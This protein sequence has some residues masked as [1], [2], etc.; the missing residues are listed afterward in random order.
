VTAGW[1]THLALDLIVP[2][3]PENRTTSD[4][5][6]HETVLPS[7]KAFAVTE[8]TAAVGADLSPTAE[9]EGQLS[10]AARHDED[11][12]KESFRQVEFNQCQEA[13][14]ILRLSEASEYCSDGR[15]SGRIVTTM[16]DCLTEET[17]G[18]AASCGETMKMMRA[19]LRM[20]PAYE[21][22]ALIGT[23]E[24]PADLFFAGIMPYLDLVD[25]RENARLIESG[26]I[27]LSQL[28]RDKRFEDNLV[29]WA[30]YWN[31]E[32]P[33]AVRMWPLLSSALSK[34]TA[35]AISFN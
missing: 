27:A 17:G 31:L 35:V 16:H 32:S 7:I 10:W 18:I 2:V 12:S 30:S 23:P 11:E 20:L 6:A 28:K 8:A 5:V 29:A 9:A 13:L 26:M 3:L 19:F 4:S 21:S 22:P 14:E 15:L 24:Y 34:N 1:I 33:E 25:P